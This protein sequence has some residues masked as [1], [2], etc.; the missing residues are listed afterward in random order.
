MPRRRADVLF[1]RA[2][3]AV[4]VDGCFWH[5]C[6]EHRTSPT[7]NAAWWQEKLAR[8]VARDRST[9]AHLRDRGWAVLRFWEHDDMTAAASQVLDIWQLRVSTRG[10]LPE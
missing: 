10:D 4:F 9:D 6:P 1:S 5:S 8:N 7:N 2:R 3:I